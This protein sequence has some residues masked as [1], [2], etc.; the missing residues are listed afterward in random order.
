[1]LALLV[2]VSSWVG[3]FKRHIENFESKR[4]SS[5]ITMPSLVE[6]E[7]LLGCPI[8]PWTYELG[9]QRLYKDKLKVWTFL[10]WVQKYCFCQ[11][12]L[13]SSIWTFFLLNMFSEITWEKNKLCTL[14][15]SRSIGSI[16]F[17]LACKSQTYFNCSRPL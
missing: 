10:Q 3:L 7:N 9:H 11:C 17:T 6:E 1:M 4:E 2:Q 14:E 5:S 8:E 16:K 15:L 12:F 13:M